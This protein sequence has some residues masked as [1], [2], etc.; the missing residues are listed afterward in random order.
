MADMQ[1]STYGSVVLDGTG[2]GTVV[3]SP[4]AMLDWRVT[5]MAVKTSQG[6]T[7]T[8]IPQCT[9]FLGVPSDG[10]IIDQTW[11]GSR[12]VSDCDIAVLHG[13][14]LYFMWE[15]GIPGTTATATVYG[16]QALGA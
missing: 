10:N 14:S 13:T 5:R 1:L 3:L 15:N 9:V 16:T 2:M 6:T 11:T 8:P 7:D 4:T 12:D